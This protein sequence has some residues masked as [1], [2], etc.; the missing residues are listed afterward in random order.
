MLHVTDVTEPFPTHFERIIFGAHREG[1]SFKIPSPTSSQ[2]SS[3]QSTSRSSSSHSEHPR[4]TTARTLLQEIRAAF[5]KVPLSDSDIFLDSDIV[6]EHKSHHYNLPSTPISFTPLDTP[7]TSPPSISLLRTTL[8]ATQSS[9]T[10]SATSSSSNIPSTSTPAITSAMSAQPIIPM[11]ACGDRSAP[12]FDPQQPRELRRFFTDLDF[13]FTRAGIVERAA[14]KKHACRYVDVDTAD[15]WESI[16]EFVDA[17]ATYED[18]VKAVHALYPGSEEERKW[19]VADMDKLVGERSRLGILSL[20]N[21]GDYFRQ[22]YTITTFLRNKRRLSEAEQSRAFV[23]GFQPDLWMRISQRLQL[24]LPDHFPDDPYALD[25]IHEAVRYVL[26]GTPSNLLTPPVLPAPAANLASTRTN[27][28]IKTED[29]AAIL[30]RIT[31]SF[32]KALMV[33]NTA[34]NSGLQTSSSYSRPPR[35]DPTSGC[36]YCGGPHFIRECSVVAEDTKNGLCKRNTE[37]RVTLPSGAFVPREI[38]GKYLKERVEEW[39]RRNPG[40][41]T[42]AQMLYKV[43]S[44]G[45]SENAEALRVIDMPPIM[46]AT[47]QTHP[48]IIT[49]S[50]QIIALLS[51]DDRI[52]SLERELFQLRGRKF[53]PQVRTRAQRKAEKGKRREE[54][55]ASPLDREPSVEIEEEPVRSAKKKVLQPEVVIPVQRDN[56]AT[57]SEPERPAITTQPEPPVHPFAEARDMTYAAP[58]NRNFSALPKPAAQKKAEPAYRTLPPIYDGKIVADVYDRAME[59]PIT[60]TQRELLSLSPEVQSQVREATSAKRTQNKDSGTKEIHTYSEDSAL[61][62]AFDD[63][64]PG[65]PQYHLPTATFINAVHQPT[66]P[67][68]GSIVIPDPYESQKNLRRSDPFTP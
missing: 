46:I 41:L 12:Q 22:F 17:T 5:A 55:S 65:D 62:D 19:S 59:A 36:N 66:T 6:P 34:N 47:R 61:A 40:Q 31:E 4:A 30:E 67:P 53:E 54:R 20:A 28:E 57:N 45:I 24:K 18:F 42:A 11:P 10:L 52:T 8:S 25:I 49:M 16:N 38:P 7:S 2:S 15:L 3:H 39:H 50:P 13:A 63:I 44:N 58:Q 26:H 56:R 32:V 29:L 35:S 60:L 43:L 9:L 21:L 64:D 33:N 51:A 23:R 14:Q 37:G 27:N 1:L 68:P 48:D